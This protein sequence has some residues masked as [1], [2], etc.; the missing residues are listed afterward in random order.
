MTIVSNFRIVACATWVGLAIAAVQALAVVQEDAAAI[1]LF[2][3]G[4]GETI[5][6]ASAN[7]NDGRAE[8]GFK[9]MEGVFGQAFWVNVGI[10]YV[11]GAESLDIR[12]ELTITA[13]LRHLDGGFDQPALLSKGPEI[14]ENYALYILKKSWTLQFVANSAF[15]R[16]SVDSEPDAFSLDE[17]RHVAVSYAEGDVK[18]YVDGELIHEEVAGGGALVPIQSDLRIGHARF[19]GGPYWW[20]GYMDD[21]GIFHRALEHEEIR[22]IMDRGLFNTLAVGPRGR[23]ALTWGGLKHTGR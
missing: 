7:E 3:E 2:E 22:E 4:E 21:L 11:P 18:M 8:K 14:D 15:G 12:D 6:D 23:A 17:W 19:V 1:Y 10:V 16:V 13:W 5:R 20:Y 9:W